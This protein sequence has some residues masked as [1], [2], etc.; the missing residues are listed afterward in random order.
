MID[1]FW[2]L[3]AHGGANFVIALAVITIGR[4]ETLNVRDRFNIPN[5][6]VRAHVTYSTGCP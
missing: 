5:D 4:G 2:K 6:D 1:V 3:I